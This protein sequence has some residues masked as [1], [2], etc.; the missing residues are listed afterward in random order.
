MSRTRRALVSLLVAL[1]MAATG[2]LVS[3]TSTSTVNANYA[4]C[5]P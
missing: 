4:C 1:A 2:G 5:A 3:A